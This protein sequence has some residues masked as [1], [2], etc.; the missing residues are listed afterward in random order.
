MNFKNIVIFLLH[1][2]L[3]LSQEIPSGVSEIINNSGLS[4][5]DIKQIMLDNDISVP[6]LNDPSQSNDLNNQNLDQIN[7]SNSRVVETLLDENDQKSNGNEDSS[8]SGDED[9]PQ[10]DDKD[11]KEE[12]I[13]TNKFSSNFGEVYFGYSAFQNDVDFF[14]SAKDI[15]VSPNHVIGPGDEVIIMLWGQTEDIS[16]YIVSRDGYLFIPNIGQVFVN[17]LTLSKLEIKLKKIYQKA[18]SSLSPVVGPASTF[19]DVSL[20]STVLKPIKIFV[21]GEV[22]KPGVYLIKPSTS[23]FT[24]LYY[25]GGPKTSGSLRNIDL[26]RSEKN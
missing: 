15:A 26:I 1:T 12:K 3:L 13:K 20:G 19:F 17:G 18:Y 5:S 2:A 4:E 22:S 24:S 8:N 25:F 16:N 9:S 14:E 23:L 11:Q 7:K 6:N 21:M 10:A